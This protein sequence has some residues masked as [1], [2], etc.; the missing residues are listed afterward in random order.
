MI[1]KHVEIKNF[2]QY[3]NIDQSFIPYYNDKNITTIIGKNGAGKS[4]LFGAIN[5]CLLDKEPDAKD[6]REKN[7][8]Y[9][10]VGILNEDVFQDASN[11]K[12]IDVSVQLTFM[13]T[14]GLLEIRIK[15]IKPFIK[16]GDN[17][18]DNSDPSKII[19]TKKV[20]K[21]EGD[22]GAWETL[23]DDDS[24]SFVKK[25]FPPDLSHFHFFDGENLDSFFKSGS[26][27]LK[28]EIHKVAQIKIVDDLVKNKLPHLRANYAGGDSDDNLK[29]LRKDLEDINKDYEASKK[30]IKGYEIN[31]DEAK[32]KIDNLN[33][34][35]RTHDDINVREKSNYIKEIEEDILGNDKILNS[36]RSQKMELIFESLPFIAAREQIKKFRDNINKLYEENKIPP[37]INKSYLE[38]LLHNEQCI[39]NASLEE[40]TS[41]RAN[42][43]KLKNQEYKL[44]DFGISLTQADQVLKTHGE[45]TN[46]F[47]TKMEK[48]IKDENLIIEKNS[49]LIKGKEKLEKQIEGYNIEAINNARLKLKGWKTSLDAGNGNLQF[50]KG[51]LSN[52]E[53][54]KIAK[55][56]EVEE[57]EKLNIK[58]DHAKKRY[59]FISNSIKLLKIVTNEAMIN[60]KNEIEQE[61]NDT[62]L[63]VM[64]NNEYDK[65][66]ISNNYKVDIIRKAGGRAQDQLSAGQS[67][68][69]AFSFIKS[70]NN[71]AGLN[72][73]VIIDTPLGRIDSENRVL[74]INS[75]LSLLKDRQ[76]ILLFTNSEYD[77]NVRTAL[78]N[79][80]NKRF[81]LE[82]KNNFTILSS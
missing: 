76:I 49:K 34:Y 7:K 33:E 75:I 77:P 3:K 36:Y 81:N 37:A 41:S 68:I 70:L 30:D 80:L 64:G 63:S 31:I 23:D 8:K 40:N 42:V 46:G 22:I 5:W 56:K 38:R 53:K 16:T 26:K 52:I 55:E 27:Q 24:K 61:T 78:K 25:F 43:E 39:C 20:A 10:Y 45:Q 60:I 67:Q 79:R 32:G 62:F 51:N 21:R 82:K 66:S 29:K 12:K 72:L 18:H 35:L 14:A 69:L 65:V 54:Q 44:G 15:R 1:L 19:I 9:S 13:D 59:D 74:I 48:I 71:K 6:N 58:N 57:A 73:P 47:K 28:E 4:N 2:R 11:R 50:E 17:S